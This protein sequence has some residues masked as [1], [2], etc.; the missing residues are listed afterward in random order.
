MLHQQSPRN[1]SCIANRNDGQL[2]EDV[3][4][5]ENVKHLLVHLA[6]IY[7]TGTAIQKPLCA[8]TTKIRFRCFLTNSDEFRTWWI[9]VI[10]PQQGHER[11]FVALNSRVCAG[12]KGEKKKNPAIPHGVNAETKVLAGI[13]WAH[14]NQV[15]AVCAPVF[16]A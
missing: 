3:F 10:L 12:L 16:L 9:C 8:T 11:A 1:R 13:R 5:W 6:L 4:H 15:L 7:D 14:E 2:P